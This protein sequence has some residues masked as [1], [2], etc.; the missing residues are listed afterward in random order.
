MV[1]LEYETLNRYTGLVARFAAAPV[2]FVWLEGRS[3]V[4]QTNNARTSAER[5]IADTLSPQGT[6]L[7]TYAVALQDTIV[8]CMR[9]V[10]DLVR[11]CCS[12]KPNWPCSGTSNLWLSRSDVL[13]V[14]ARRERREHDA[15]RAGAAKRRRVQVRTVGKQSGSDPRV[16]RGLRRGSRRHRG[17]RSGHTLEAWTASV[18]IT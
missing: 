3:S 12:W 15:R 18:K 14:A 8:D 5:T 17:S 10:D 4:R 13:E 1:A 2:A 6:T 16:R 7:L 9:V 11:R